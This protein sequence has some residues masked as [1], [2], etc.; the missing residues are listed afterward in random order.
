MIEQLLDEGVGPDEEMSTVERVQ[1]V[2]D[3][4]NSW[5]DLAIKRLHEIHRLTGAECPSCAE[6]LDAST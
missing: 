4:F 2:I 1:D 6:Y 5:T 3:G